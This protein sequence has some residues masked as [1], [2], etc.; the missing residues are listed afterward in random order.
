MQKRGEIIDGED[1][2]PVRKTYPNHPDT[3]RKP[4]FTDMN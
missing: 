4:E 3:S 2:L 1:F